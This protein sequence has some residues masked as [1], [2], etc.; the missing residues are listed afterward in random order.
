M[1]WARMTAVRSLPSGT[2]LQEPGTS[3]AQ[4]YFPITAVVAQINVASQDQSMAVAL[5]GADG[6]MGVGAILGAQAT[7]HRAVVV[8]AG[9]V[10]RLDAQALRA[11]M[12]RVAACRDL[13]LACVQ[14]HIEAIAQ[15]VVCHQFHPLEARLATRLL[16]LGQDAE[17]ARLDLTQDELA[18]LLGV[19]REAVNQ[20]I[21]TWRSLG[22]LQG[23]RGWLALDDPP[24]LATLACACHGIGRKQ[25]A[26]IF[27]ALQPD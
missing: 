20:I 11:E 24:G 8:R 1:R 18:G 10:L 27:K 7:D 4:V 23:G 21:G 16:K 9:S 26:R 2:V 3:I 13:A 6:L 12:E 22:L 25:R 5:F 19:R 14:A 15:S 17:S